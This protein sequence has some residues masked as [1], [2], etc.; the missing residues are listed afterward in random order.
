MAHFSSE[1]RWTLRIVLSSE[2][3]ETLHI[4]LLGI[5]KNSILL[6]CKMESLFSFVPHQEFFLKWTCP[7]KGFPDGS[8]GKKICLQWKR[9]KLDPWLGKIPWKRE[10]ATYSSIIAWKIPWTRECGGLQSKGSQ[11]VRHDGSPKDTHIYTQWIWRC[12]F[13]VIFWH[14]CLRHTPEL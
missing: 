5:R 1:N 4:Q 14:S 8:A 7:L 10:M 12:L 11:R 2:L 13:V 6:S 3:Q 9:C